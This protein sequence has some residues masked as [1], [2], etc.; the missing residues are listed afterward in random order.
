MNCAEEK[1]FMGRDILTT[2]RLGLWVIRISQDGTHRQMFADRVMLDNLGVEEELTPEEC[3]HYWYDRIDN[4]YLY[5]MNYTIDEAIKSGK[6]VEICYTWNHPKKGDTTVRC[7]GVRVPDEDGMI[8]LQ[9]HHREISDVK[10]RHFIQDFYRAS[11]SEKIAY[12]EVDLE[13]RQILEIGGL[14]EEY[15]EEASANND[16]HYIL[17]RC[18]ESIVHQE[19]IDDFTSFF[20]QN[21]HDDISCYENNTKKLQYRRLLDGRMQWVELTAHV[22]AEQ[23]SENLFA[24]IYLRNIDA[25]KQRELAQETAATQ[26]SLTG[27]YNRRVFE[28]KVA[29]HMLAAGPERSSALVLIDLDNFKFINDEYGHIEGDRVLKNMAEAMMITF[30]KKDLLGRLGGD[31][32]LVFLRNVSDKDTIDCRMKELRACFARLNQYGSTCSI[33]IAIVD[34]EHFSFNESLHKADVALYQSKAKGRN[35]YTYYTE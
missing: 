17:T 13:S 3:Y 9:G 18:K 23:F 12:M 15:R 8:C 2:T 29:E 34:S 22:F 14:W 4:R 19:D 20:G 7:L 25:Q 1:I 24:L 30:R 10:N 32:F 5:Y 21:L 6:I 26:D 31:E 11:L 27:V 33:G 28:E 35:R 16:Y